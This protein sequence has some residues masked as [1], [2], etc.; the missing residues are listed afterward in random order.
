MKILP[1]D[2]ILTTSKKG[3]LS[4]AILSILNFFQRDEVRFQHVMMAVDDYICIEAQNKIT[5]NYTRERMR[6]FK[7]YKI[8]RNRNLTDEDREKIVHRARSMRGHDYGYIRLFLQLLDQVFRTN[9][10]TK[11][12]KDSNY[13][14]CSSL[15][16]WAYYVET[17]IKFNGQKWMAVEPDDI[18]D[19]SL[20][21]EK[22]WYTVIE[23][24]KHEV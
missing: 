6:D 4:Q 1:A 5:F 2:V 24:E 15:I 19:E 3:W 23:W 20:K 9:W 11:R 8:I 21:N 7:R 12:I 22:D 16:A 13:Q 18:D 14:I 10:F 17:G